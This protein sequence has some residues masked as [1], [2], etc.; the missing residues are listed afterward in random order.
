MFTLLELLASAITAGVT[1][2]LL[3]ERR[4]ARS[5]TVAKAEELYTL[6]ESFEQT[7]VSRLIEVCSADDAA[8]PTWS[9]LTRDSAKARMLVSFYFPALWPEVRAA[10][11][12]VSRATAA[13]RDYRFGPRDEN[14]ALAVEQALSEA[15]ENLAA[16]KH[17]VVQ[18]RRDS[19]AGL[20]RSLA[21][22]AHA[23]A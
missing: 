21:R 6:I 3:L 9:G 19:A 5:F 8:E 20:V 23:P 7:L 18:R 2:H 22:L 4:E 11:A 12:G 17:A 16:L 14:A 10:D 1:C 15:R 13:A